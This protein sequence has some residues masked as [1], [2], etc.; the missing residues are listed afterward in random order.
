MP[1]PTGGSQT[2]IAAGYQTTGAPK[3]RPIVGFG[4]L[5]YFY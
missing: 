4:L 5:G 3:Q 1:K 2:T